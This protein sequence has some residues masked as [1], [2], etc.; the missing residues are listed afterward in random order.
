MKVSEAISML[1]KY[2]KPDDDI[3][4]AWWDKEWAERAVKPLTDDQWTEVAEYFDNNG[5]NLGNQMTYDLNDAIEWMFEG[6]NNG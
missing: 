4:I 5:D 3:V 2:Y 1:D 6:D